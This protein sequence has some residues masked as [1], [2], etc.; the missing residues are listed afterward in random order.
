[1]KKGFKRLSLLLLMML[2]TVSLL[3]GCGPKKPAPEEA[4]AYVKAVLDLMCT[5]DYDHSVNLADV[6]EGKET[7]VRDNLINE[8]MKGISSQSAL[9]EEVT[10]D[11]MVFMISALEKTKYSVGEAAATEDG[12]YDVTVSVEPL[13]IFTGIDEKLNEILEEKVASE[14]DKIL[15]M[16]E[17]EQT[18]YVMEILIDLLNKKLDDPKY[19]KAE[20][21][22]VHYG[23]L[24]G[25]KGV[26]GC[27][28][29]EGEKLGSK[30]FSSSD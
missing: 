24:E 5:G 6:E 18:N 11:F 19:D 23:P 8:M 26:Y 13:Q 3:S 1:M 27:T 28:E 7:E 14:P 21:V 4:Q 15:E 29:D 22:V 25:Q 10:S 2:L 16:S 12:G 20:E 9:N 30:L 17:E